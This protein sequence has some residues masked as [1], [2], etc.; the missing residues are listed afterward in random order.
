MLFFQ[1]VKPNPKKSCGPYKPQQASFDLSY[2]N[3]PSKYSSDNH[4]T[5]GM[6]VI[7]GNGHVVPGTSTNGAKYKIPG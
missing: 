1:D 6:I 3:M 7:A 4:D 5:I 2:F